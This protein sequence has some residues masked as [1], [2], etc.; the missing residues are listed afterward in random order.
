MAGISKCGGEGCLKRE[1][2]ERF[3]ALSNEY[4]QSWSDFEKRKDGEQC[5]NFVDNG[6]EEKNVKKCEK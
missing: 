2:C 5:D 4:W 6:K 3:T 1:R